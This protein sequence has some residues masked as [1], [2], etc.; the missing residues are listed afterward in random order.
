M[1]PL[2]LNLIIPRSLQ[3]A[4]LN[5]ASIPFG[6]VRANTPHA[7][8]LVYS[9]RR[10]VTANIKT[11]GQVKMGSF[12]FGVD[13]DRAGLSLVLLTVLFHAGDIYLLGVAEPAD[14]FHGVRELR[15]YVFAR[16]F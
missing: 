13:G 14:S 10:A 3:R 5:G 7:K 9:D 16:P 1:S 12:P 11:D 2:A 8:C 6:R 15:A 4:P